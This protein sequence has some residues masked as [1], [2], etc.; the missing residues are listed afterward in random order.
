MARPKNT[1]D[2]TDLDPDE[3]VLCI[4]CG[5]RNDN[6]TPGEQCEGCGGTFHRYA[7]VPVRDDEITAADLEERRVR[8]D[9]HS[10]QYRALALLLEDIETGEFTAIKP[11]DLSNCFS[12][13]GRIHR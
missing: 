8:W 6:A 12:A 2:P 11:Y 4:D 13:A 5:I 7:R 10:R 3:A 9:A 1:D